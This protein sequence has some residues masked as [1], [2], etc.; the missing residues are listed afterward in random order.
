MLKRPASKVL[1]RPGALRRPAAA[2]LANRDT[3]KFSELRQK[4]KEHLAAELKQEAAASEQLRK[5]IITELL[6]K[7]QQGNANMRRIIELLL[8]VS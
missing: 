7:V 8:E 5:Q 6:V 2:R 1:K 3:E 4:E